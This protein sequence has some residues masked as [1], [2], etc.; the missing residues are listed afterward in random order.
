MRCAV[1]IERR[2]RRLDVVV[3]TIELDF[4]RAVSVKSYA[5]HQLCLSHAAK[6]FVNCRARR[7]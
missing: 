7:L 5:T 6:V 4:V 3:V 1:A 2:G